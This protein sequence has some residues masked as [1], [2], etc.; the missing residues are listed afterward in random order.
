M[1]KRLEKR[2]ASYCRKQ[3]YVGKRLTVCTFKVLNYIEHKKGKKAK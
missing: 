2:A 3:G 1:P